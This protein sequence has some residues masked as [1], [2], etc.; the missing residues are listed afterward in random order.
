[1]NGS[2]A[3]VAGAR[4]AGLAWEQEAAAPQPAERRTSSESRSES[5]LVPRRASV[6][7]PATAA[8]ATTEPTVPWHA[9]RM[10]AAAL[11]QPA[12]V[13]RAAVKETAAAPAEPAERR[14]PTADITPQRVDAVAPATHVSADAAAWLFGIVLVAGV[15]L[16]VLLWW[17]LSP[18]ESSAPRT[19]REAPEQV[20]PRR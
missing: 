17:L 4:A 8:M 18:A 12:N 2:G 7:G 15:A 16:L 20:Q 10:A 13:P 5:A 9:G 14:S 6:N 3:P 1:M 11:P 19:Q